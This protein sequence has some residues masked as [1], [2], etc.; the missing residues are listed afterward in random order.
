MHG[1]L[2][3]LEC[4]IE[5]CDST[6]IGLDNVWVKAWTTNANPWIACEIECVSSTHFHRN[7]DCFAPVLPKP[8]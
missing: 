1:V 3:Q 5:G 8:G 2:C 4:A 6:L 7:S